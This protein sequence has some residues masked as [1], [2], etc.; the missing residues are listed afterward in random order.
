[1]DGGA[2][3]V[4]RGSM[5]SSMTKWRQ[6]EWAR[7]WKKRS[8]EKSSERETTKALFYRSSEIALQ[9]FRQ[10]HTWMPLGE[11]RSSRCHVRHAQELGFPRGLYSGPYGISDRLSHG[12]SAIGESKEGMDVEAADDLETVVDPRWNMRLM[13]LLRDCVVLATWRQTR[14]ATTQDKLTHTWSATS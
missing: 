8:A 2:E 11:D 10:W 5:T 9:P 12:A 4:F 7:R 13:P 14:T 6:N 3:I 1:M